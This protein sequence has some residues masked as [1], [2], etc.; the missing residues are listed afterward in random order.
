M[1]NQRTI[2]WALFAGFVFLTWSTWQQQF[3]PMADMTETSIPVVAE[4]SAPS[5]DVPDVVVE[6]GAPDAGQFRTAYPGPGF[7]QDQRHDRANPV[8]PGSPL[9]ARAGRQYDPYL[10]YGGL[11][12]QGIKPANCSWIPSLGSFPAGR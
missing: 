1:D 9:P 7:L 11:F 10:A 4:D 5:V 3:A 6:M 2:L 12:A 8:A